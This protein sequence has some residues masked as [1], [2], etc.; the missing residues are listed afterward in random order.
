MK[1][2]SKAITNTTKQISAPKHQIKKLP[3]ALKTKQQQE[4]H[5]VTD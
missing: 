2:P 3:K 4:L 5:A 1:L